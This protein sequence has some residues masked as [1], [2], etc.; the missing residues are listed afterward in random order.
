MCLQVANDLGLFDLIVSKS[1]S[2]Q[3]MASVT[4][5]DEK[6]IVRIMRM[7]VAVGFVEQSGDGVY[8]ATPMT[9]VMTLPS[10]KAGV[11][12]NF[13]RLRLSRSGTNVR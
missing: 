11:E 8:S 3:E 6:L 12:R 4:G 5:A 2:A 9:R 1:R 7:M 13:T 10:V